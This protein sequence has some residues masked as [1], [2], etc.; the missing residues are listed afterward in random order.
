MGGHRVDGVRKPARNWGL[1]VLL[2]ICVEFWVIV[3]ATVT[4]NL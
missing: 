1:F 3:T 4:Q 2:G